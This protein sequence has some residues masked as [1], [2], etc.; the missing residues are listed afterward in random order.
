MRLV[1]VYWVKFD[2]FPQLKQCKGT[3]PFGSSS[4]AR[5]LGGGLYCECIRALPV[6]VFPQEFG[7][8]GAAALEPST[9]SN[10]RVRLTS[11]LGA[12][13]PEGTP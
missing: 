7:P 9:F 11:P 6:W 1:G 13:G 12:V 10:A 4:W 5:I 3:Y 8:K 2:W